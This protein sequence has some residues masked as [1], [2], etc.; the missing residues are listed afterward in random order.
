MSTS[1]Q[2]IVV[3]TLRCRVKDRHAKVLS[4]LAR[5]VN[6]VWNYDNELSHKHTQRTGK[7]LSAYDLHQYTTGATK[8]GISLHSQT[9][10]AIN[11]EFA[12]RRKQ[13]KRAKLAWRKS[14][15]AHRSLGWVP[16]KASAIR[17]KDGRVFYGK[18]AFRLWD[19]YGLATYDLGAGSFSEDARGHWYFNVTVKTRVPSA[20]VHS[21]ASV[22]SYDAPS[23]GIDLGL[24]DLLA[25]SDGVKVPAGRFYRNLEPALAT[26]QRAGKKRRVK[27]IH[28]RIANHR[29]DQLHKL[30][31]SLV[32]QYAAIFVGNVNASALAKTRMAKSVLDAGWSAFRTMLQYKCADAGAWFAEVDE[33]HSTQ[34]CSSCGAL[35]P[36]R[37]KG[38]AGLGIREWTC[39]CGATHDRDI[40]AARNIL[41]LGHER[42]AAGI[43][44]L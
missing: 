14:G 29:K 24:K 38:I 8:E 3:R 36:E 37:P 25:T 16:F 6:L 21:E 31:R 20:P 11:E 28:A 10:Q 34:T 44:A 17:F 13:F 26:A 42:L 41:A 1:S 32:N 40:N 22:L 2:N 7:F 43:P 35:P 23:V 19:S 15:G 30:S 18:T 33:A 9:V 27:A 12:T 4:G 39:A 5:E